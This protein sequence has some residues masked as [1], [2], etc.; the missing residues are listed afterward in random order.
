M[1]L[2]EVCFIRLAS[3]VSNPSEES[4]EK[5]PDHKQASKP[6]KTKLEPKETPIRPPEAGFLF[7]MLC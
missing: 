2:T 6:A 1:K 7:K 5:A 4:V 3:H